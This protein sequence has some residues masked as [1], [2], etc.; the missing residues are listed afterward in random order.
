MSPLRLFRIR[1]TLFVYQDA[2]DEYHKNHSE[3]L[4]EDYRKFF[5]RTSE[6]SFGNPADLDELRGKPPQE[7]LMKA[8]DM[9]ADQHNI[10]E[11]EL[12]QLRKRFSEEALKVNKMEKEKKERERRES[13]SS[14]REQEEN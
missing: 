3:N 7:I 5:R 2:F 11:E 4:A 10:R 13:G 9:L 1:L 12:A 14:A 6:P 8:M